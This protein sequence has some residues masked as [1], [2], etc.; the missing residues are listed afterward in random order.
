MAESILG[1]R[2]EGKEI[3]IC[4]TTHSTVSWLSFKYPH[5]FCSQMK[6]EDVVLLDQVH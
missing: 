3:K 6:L 2:L 4:L 1:P 5:E